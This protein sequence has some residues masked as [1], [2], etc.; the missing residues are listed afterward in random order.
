MRQN[1]PP[2]PG[3]VFTPKGV[4]SVTPNLITKTL[5]AAVSFLGSDL[6][7]LPSEVT[8]CS[9]R[10]SGATALLVAN[11]DTDVI[12]LLGRWRSDEMLRYL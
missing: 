7:F 5:R 11:V 3:Q 2:P 6:G 12:R 1:T 10:A 4:Q 9:L 8:A